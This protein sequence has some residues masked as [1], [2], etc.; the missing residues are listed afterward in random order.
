MKLKQIKKSF[1]KRKIAVK[2]NSWDLLDARL[3]A[4]ETKHSKTSKSIV[5]YIMAVAAIVVLAVCIYPFLN[6]DII[7]HQDKNEIVVDKSDAINNAV[8]LKTKNDIL[9]L[10]RISLKKESDFIIEGHSLSTK[11]KKFQKKSSITNKKD[12]SVTS[13]K[14]NAI[15]VNGIKTS[16]NQTPDLVN[17]E[18]HILSNT[19]KETM[20]SLSTTA[21]KQDIAQKSSV[22]QEMEALLNDALKKQTLLKT[23]FEN[24]GSYVQ[25]LIRE[26]EWDIESD[27]RNKLD[28]FIFDQLG[29]LKTEAYALVDKRD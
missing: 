11:N 21:V 26:T 2:D 20:S 3:D 29:K 9:K 23:S 4:A 7:S 13:R 12:A 14:A 1:E 27:R 17:R 5:Y 28:M 16:V 18:K 22:D 25:Q 24:Q 10:D 6:K 8:D 19:I 15:A